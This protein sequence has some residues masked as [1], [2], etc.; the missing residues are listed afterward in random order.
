MGIKV[1]GHIKATVR[2]EE[3]GETR[4]YEYHNKATNALL[5]RIAQALGDQPMIGVSKFQMGTGTGTV[6]STDTALFTPVSASIISTAAKSVSGNVMTVSINYPANYTTGT[7]KEAGALD[8]NN[9][10]LT[11]F[12]LSP[13]LQI[14]AN[15]SVTFLYTI[16]ISG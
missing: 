10:L 7:F 5:S 6:A 16:T 9:V 14:V 8:K 3:T 13:N 15:E 2:N 11:H 1:I 4:E 12:L